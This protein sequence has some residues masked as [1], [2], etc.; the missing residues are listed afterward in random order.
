MPTAMVAVFTVVEVL[1]LGC[2]LVTLWLYSRRVDVVKRMVHLAKPVKAASTDGKVVYLRNSPEVI[3]LYPVLD[4]LEATMRTSM[5]GF[6][7]AAYPGGTRRIVAIPNSNDVATIISLRRIA[8]EYPFLEILPVP[9]TDDPSWAPV[10]AAWDRNPKAYWWHTGKRARERALPAK[11]TRQLVYAFYTM[12]ACQ[13]SALLSYIDADSVVPPDYFVSAAAGI[14]Q[15]EVLQN[16]NVAG[17]AMASWASSMFALDHMLWDGSL[18]QHMTARGRHPFYV[19]GKGLFFR[20]S[21]LIEVGGFNPW[22][23]IEDPE[24]GMRLWTNG[25]RLGIIRSPLIEEVPDTFGKGITQR[26]R[27]IAG[28]FQSL[29]KPLTLMGMN[30]VSVFR[31]RLNL[32]PCASLFLNPFGAVVGV[33]A[34]IA[35]IE[36]PGRVFSTWLEVLCIATLACLLLALA[37]GQ[38]AIIRQTGLIFESRRERLGYV[39][40]VN[41]VFMFAYWV[42]WSIPLAIGFWMDLTDR[43]LTWQR[44]DKIDANHDL[45]RAGTVAA[46]DDAAI[47]EVTHDMVRSAEA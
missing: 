29:G 4:E 46:I 47:A 19:L 3:V 12:A 11:K 17:N 32:V 20:I 31:A 45:V 34:L 14:K 16:T 22:L 1:Y 5:L 7:R 36:E 44:T 23:T 42:W 40:R 30:W 10:W 37:I 9:P 35:A 43:G 27:W 21:D 26:K 18:Y 8:Q 25:C 41:P 6:A 39:L 28:F 2:L 33:W 13:P 38:R 15:F 24:V